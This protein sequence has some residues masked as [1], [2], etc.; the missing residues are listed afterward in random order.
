[1]YVF[2]HLH[3]YYSCCVLYRHLFILLLLSCICCCGTEHKNSP[4][5]RSIEQHLILPWGTERGKIDPRS[6]LHKQAVWDGKEKEHACGI[7][8]Q[9]SEG[10]IVRGK[11]KLRSLTLAICT[12]LG[13]SVRQEMGMTSWWVL[14][15]VLKQNH[16]NDAKNVRL[17]SSDLIND[18][19][20]L[21]I[22]V[23]SDSRVFFWTSLVSV[24]Q[25]QAHT[26]TETPLASGKHRGE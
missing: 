9:T 22:F 11:M 5:L 26:H 20:S 21:N 13:N 4:R 17:L 1:V 8:A 18:T 16:N 3:R 14:N 19:G 6:L 23:Q 15:L 25:I 12:T 24:F 10:K 7:T 2:V